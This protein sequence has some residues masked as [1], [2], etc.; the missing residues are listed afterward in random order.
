M[1]LD[2]EDR[3]AALDPNSDGYGFGLTVAVRQRAGNQA[4]TG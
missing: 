3:I 1:A 2:I 4:L